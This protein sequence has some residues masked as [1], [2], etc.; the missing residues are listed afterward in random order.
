MHFPAQPRSAAHRE[1]GAALFL[2]MIFLILLSVLALTASST[3]I[4]QERM[5]GGLRSSQLGLMGAES[6]LRGG[7]SFLWNLSFNNQQNLPPCLAGSAGGD[8]VFFVRDDGTLEPLVQAFRTSQD[9]LDPGTDG[10]RAYAQ[11]ISGLT[12]GSVTASVATQPRFMIEHLGPALVGEFRSG[13]AL[14]PQGTRAQPGDFHLYR[15]TARSQ[16]GTDAVVRVAESF[17]TAINLSNTG[18][19]PDAP[20]TP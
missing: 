12:G 11:T 17:Y 1:R 5:V 9:W 7:E 2:A 16:G 13:G 19:N 6:T 8:C 4:L 14:F 18:F 20:P 10:A 15:I 3:S